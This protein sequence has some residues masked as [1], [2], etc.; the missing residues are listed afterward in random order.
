MTPP[1]DQEPPVRA[2]RRS[3]LFQARPDALLV[4]EWVP[5]ITLPPPPDAPLEPDDPE[6]AQVDEH[7]LPTF[8]DDEPEERLSGPAR[9]F[10]GMGTHGTRVSGDE[11]DEEA[12][13]EWVPDDYFVA[14]LRLPRPE[15][16]L[17]FRFGA[18]AGEELSEDDEVALE[19]A[20]DPTLS[21]PD[22]AAPFSLSFEEPESTHLGA[23]GDEEDDLL[24]DEESTTGDL[25][26]LVSGGLPPL[27][28]PASSRSSSSAGGRSP[29]AP[30][31]AAVP[32]EPLVESSGDASSPPEPQPRRYGADGADAADGVE[33]DDDSEEEEGGARKGREP[34]GSPFHWGMVIV[35]L[36]I[37]GGLWLLIQAS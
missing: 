28:V 11:D 17:P 14:E 34:L 3:R 15:D 31:L 22:L 2:A 36:F 1:R 7:G 23:F 30:P 6:Q 37:A 18:V 19:E 21:M 32:P 8:E 9:L 24:D 13:G 5:N 16:G 12:E 27:S 33:G 25:D 10:V 26:D 4:E 35:A 29:E 20:S